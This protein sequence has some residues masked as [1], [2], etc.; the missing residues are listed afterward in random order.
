[1]HRIIAF[2]AILLFDFTVLV[3]DPG[4]IGLSYFRVLPEV[5]RLKE[6]VLLSLPKAAICQRYGL[7]IEGYFYRSD[8]NISNPTKDDFSLWVI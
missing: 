5:V 7:V 2:L 6:F 4:E 8:S 3:A 1:M